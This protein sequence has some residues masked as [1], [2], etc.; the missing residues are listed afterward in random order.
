V[1]NVTDA[2]TPEDERGQLYDQLAGELAGEQAHLVEQLGG[3]E[4][5]GTSPGFDEGFADSGQVAAEQGESRA[6]AS[7]LREQL[8]DVEAAIARLAEGTYGRCEVCGN[9]IGEDR[10]EAM[11]ATRYCIEHASG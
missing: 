1:V 10:L 3:L 5:S 11:P 7:R 6:L 9:E 2:A 4:G 8:D